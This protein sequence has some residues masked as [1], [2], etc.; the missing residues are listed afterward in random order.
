MQQLNFKGGERGLFVIDGKTKVCSVLQ[1]NDK[2]QTLTLWDVEANQEIYV[3]YEVARTSL[4]PL[5]S[6]AADG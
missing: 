1:Q 6:E 3:T 5:S 2:T 4:I